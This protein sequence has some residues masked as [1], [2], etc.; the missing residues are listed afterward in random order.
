LSEELQKKLDLGLKQGTL[1]GDVWSQ[2]H[3]GLQE[4]LSIPERHMAWQYLNKG[5]HDEED[6]EDFEIGVVR[7]IVGALTK[8]GDSFSS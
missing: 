3:E 5:T 4:M 2:R 7:K 1:R 8:I 6:R